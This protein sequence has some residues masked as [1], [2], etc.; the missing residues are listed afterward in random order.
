MA[1][2]HAIDPGFFIRC[3]VNGCPRT[4]QNFYSF[5][6]HLYRKHRDTLQGGMSGRNVSVSNND[7]DMELEL[8]E[9]RESEEETP[10]RFTRSTKFEHKKQM[11]LF[12]LKTKEV[13]K[14]SQTALDGILV[15]VSQ[16][17]QQT[18]EQVKIEVKDCLE[19]KGMSI[20][21]FD[22]LDNVFRDPCKTEPF[23]ELDSKHLQEKFYRNH[24]HLL[25]RLCKSTLIMFY[26]C[27]LRNQK[28]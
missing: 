13:R 20:D 15:D 3:G 14:V 1:A 26:L 17:I 27:I 25:V 22:G 2:V 7:S 19:K 16:L 6:K 21:L 18:I 11:A 10:V 8:L 23:R 9:T 12:L 4:Y 28:K 5:K 24:L